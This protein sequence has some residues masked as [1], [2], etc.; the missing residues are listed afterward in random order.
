M[1]STVYMVSYAEQIAHI[2]CC[3]LYSDVFFSLLRAAGIQYALC[4]P[5]LVALAMY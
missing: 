1:G 3:I 4:P 5:G 2:Q